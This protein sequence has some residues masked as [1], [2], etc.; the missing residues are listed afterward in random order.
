MLAGIFFTSFL[1]ALSGAMMP[2]PLTTVCI[3][4]SARRG[5]RT[6]PLLILG[7][8]I[9]ELAL[10]CA[11]FLGLAA[12]VRDDRVMGLVGIV[13]GVILIIMGAGMLRGAARLTLS[14]A[15]RTSGGM[16]PIL[17][18]AVVSLANPYW[19]IWW[20]TIGLGY[21]LI[22]MKSGVQGIAAFLSGHILADASWYGLLALSVTMGRRFISDRIYRGVVVCCAVFLVGFGL[23]FGASGFRT[24]L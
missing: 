13:G 15:P 4:E 17:A 14:A 1:V 19:I 12:Y 7:H 16:H 2:G 11:L 3:S 5:A 21:I 22:S 20:A 8:G 9:L 18:G 6:G 23:Y 24:L 10:A